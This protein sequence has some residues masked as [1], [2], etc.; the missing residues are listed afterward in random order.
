MLG[1]SSIRRAIESRT[2]DTTDSSQGGSRSSFSCTILAAKQRH[3]YTIADHAT[4][5]ADATRVDAYANAL[6]RAVHPDSIVADLG[7]GIGTFA[8]LAARFGARTI[9]AIEPDDAIHV[10]R[11]IAEASGLA[12]RI[13]FMQSRSTDVTLPERAT[14]IV[15]D[16]RGALPFFERHIPAIADARKRLLADGGVLIPRRD[17]VWAAVVESPDLHAHHVA[18][19][20]D[21]THGLD[22][23]PATELL[24]NTWRRLRMTPDALL[25]NSECLATLDY[26]DISSPDLDAERTWSAARSGTGHGLGV[27]FDSELIDGVSFSNAPDLPRAIHAHAFFPFAAPVPLGKAKRFRCGCRPRSSA[28][29]TC[30]AGRAAAVCSRRFTACRSACS[31]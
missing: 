1:T 12:D 5:M 9:Y 10:G 11:A 8:L 30:G 24:A 14:I 20:G 17:R 4:M 2:R 18:P 28:T 13:Q 25:S 22:F 27:W 16:M 29:I 26:R 31:S 23:R 15:S 3:M 21:R 19:W 7:A 6:R